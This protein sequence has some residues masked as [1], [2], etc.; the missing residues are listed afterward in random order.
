MNSNTKGDAYQVSE[1]N[2]ALKYSDKSF[3]ENAIMT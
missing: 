2:K 3:V 1:R